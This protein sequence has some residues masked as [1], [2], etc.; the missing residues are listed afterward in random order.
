ME[1]FKTLSEYFKD[2]FGFKVAKIGI[3]AGLSC[4]NRDNGSG[5]CL[6]CTDAGAGEFAGNP[7]LSISG[8]IAEGKKT[9]DLKWNCG[10]YIA[11]FQSFSNT[12]APMDILRSKFDEAIGSDGILGLA[13]ATRPDCI[14]GEIVNL[15]GE[16]DKRTFLWI[17]LGFQTSNEN[18]ASLVNRGYSNEVFDKAVGLLHDK[19]IKIVV[20]LIAGLPG[21]GRKEFLESV[22]Y[23]NRLKPWGIKFHSIYIQR[24]SRLA[25]Y[26]L[27][28][29]FDPLSMSE[30]ID[31]ISDAILMLDKNIIIHRMTGDPDRRLLIKPFWACDKLRVLSGIRRAVSMKS[32]TQN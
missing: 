7:E 28:A 8:Q 13:I 29:G 27:A 30:Y 3:N 19:G 12:Y 23:V 24:N 21:E 18:T 14:D 31:F 15:L 20:H 25:E 26:S 9:C 5:G 11:Y 32:K 17:E 2:E 16:Y 1:G 4:P 22:K 10:G 6:F